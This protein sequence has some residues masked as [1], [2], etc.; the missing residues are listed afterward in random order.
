[1][2][3]QDYKTHLN[4]WICFNQ[5]GIIGKN[6]RHIIAES[7]KRSKA[8]LHGD[9]ECRAFIV[10]PSVWVETLRNNT[11]LRHAAKVVMNQVLPMVQD[12]IEMMILTDTM[13]NIIEVIGE[14]DLLKRMDNDMAIKA[15]YNF[16]EASVGTTALGLT[17][18]DQKPHQVF[19]SEHYCRTLA[20]FTTSA[21]PVFD[22][23]GIVI[24]NL[25]FIQS[26]KLIYKNTMA[27]LEATALFIQKQFEM[28]ES[29]DMINSLLDGPNEL[30][31]CDKGFVVRRVT[32]SAEAS[33]QIDARDILY[34]DIRIFFH[35]IDFTK[36][37]GKNSGTF[38]SEQRFT[39]QKRHDK[40]FL[41]IAPIIIHKIKTIGYIVTLRHDDLTEEMT[42]ANNSYYLYHFED[43]I[44][45]NVK[46]LKTI[47]YAKRMAATNCSILLEG[48]SGTGKELF[49]QSIHNASNR[50]NGP[51]VAINCASLPKELVESELFGYEKGTFT[52][53]LTKGKKGKFE[54]ADK[55]TIFLDEVG[56]LPLETQAK[57]LRFLDNSLI[58]RI[59]SELEKKIDVR[60]IA[61]TNRSLSVDV[62]QGHFRAD[63]FYRL[64]VIGVTLPSLNERADD[65]ELLVRHFIKK[66][67]KE[68]GIK[69]SASKEF[70]DVMKRAVW[71]G[72]VREL[73]NIVARAYYYSEDDVIGL[74]DLPEKMELREAAP[75]FQI[76][77]GI[78]PLKEI[79]KEAIIASIMDAGGNILEAAKKLKMSKSTIYRK[80]EKYGITLP[81]SKHK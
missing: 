62:E 28:E 4:D 2:T 54:M 20:S 37:T 19:G 57:L 7:W 73:Q 70:V 17:L 39:F 32:R 22:D 25:C 68:N 72:N 23:T 10:E 40:V 26:N 16:T 50:L 8:A 49:A 1:M 56:E 81:D 24:G 77:A 80:I 46:M 14:A 27:T 31:V 5:E 45:N 51:F 67:N 47:E 42:K 75:I 33:L 59:G 18:R 41:S 71:K 74:G 60:V 12:F 15:G 9:A 61:A 64:N 6:V 66:M 58:S 55:G 69:K 29:S 35:D 43:I 53:A 44:S 21:M 11:D 13:G 79:E 52:G 34:K 30:I 36:V 78:R 76:D 63:L 65:I 38:Y 3:E 48:D